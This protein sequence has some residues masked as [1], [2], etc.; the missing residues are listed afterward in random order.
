MAMAE[1]SPI[2]PRIRA[3]SKGLATVGV[4]T[5]AGAVLAAGVRRSTRARPSRAETVCRQ[6]G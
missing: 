3:V 1:R 2:L 4:G 6:G 5:R